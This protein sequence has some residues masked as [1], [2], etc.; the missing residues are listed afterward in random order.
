MLAAALRANIPMIIFVAYGIVGAI[1]LPRLYA[2]QIDVVPMRVR[3]LN[4][5]E[6]MERFT[7]ATQR[8]LPTSQK[9]DHR[10]LPSRDGDGRDLCLCGAHA[11][12]CMA[13]AGQDGR[14]RSPD[15]RRHRHRQRGGAGQ[16]GPDLLPQRRLCADRQ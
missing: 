16:R 13:S 14:R 15:P 2:G 7:Y 9:S 8:L 4:R 3:A 10:H 12:G 5:Y 6:S 11:Q 1:L